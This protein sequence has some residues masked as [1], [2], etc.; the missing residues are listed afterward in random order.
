MDIKRLNEELERYLDDGIKI[1]VPQEIAYYLQ[2]GDSEISEEDKAIADKY[3]KMG[4]IEFTYDELFG[5]MTDDFG[6]ASK[7]TTII[8]HPKED[9]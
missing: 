3:N 8:I 4:E 6:F 9:K 2:Y 1:I 7:A 5:E